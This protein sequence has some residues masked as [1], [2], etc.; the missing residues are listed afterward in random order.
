LRGSWKETI[1]H[2]FSNNGDGYYP[3]AG[4]SF[5][6]SGN[7][8]GTT[9]S[10]GGYGY[11]IVYKLDADK[12]GWHEVPLFAFDG[13]NNNSGPEGYLTITSSGR[14]FGTL[15]GYSDC[16]N[17][18][19]G[20]VFELSRSHGQWVESIVYSFD[21]THGANPN[22]GLMMGKDETFYGS[23]LAGGADN[24]GVVFELKPGKVWTIRLLYQFTGQGA[25]ESPNPG[26]IFGPHGDLY[27]TTPGP[28][29]EGQYDGEVFEVSP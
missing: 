6:K 19:C 15:R 29:Y 22:P 5:D 27:G 26:L 24:H 10:G 2:S 13:Q 20:S 21:E 4:V 25:D 14:I 17:N 7:L 28:S 18:Q 11:G 9:W 3:N 16:Y 12:K 8:Y 23:A 1:L